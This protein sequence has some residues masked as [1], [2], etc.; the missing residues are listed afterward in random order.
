MY[1]YQ[2]E[3][4]SAPCELHIDALSA[5]IADTAAKVVFENAKR[6]EQ[7]YSFFRNDSELHTLN[8]RS[9]NICLLSDELSGLIQLSLF[10]RD[11]T[12]GAFDIAMA[13]TLKESSNA[14]STLEYHAKRK[15]LLPFASS[16]HLSLEGNCLTFTNPITK[17]DLGGLVKEYAVDQSI[18][19]LQSMEITS[20][21][22]NFGGDIAAFGTCH[23]HSWRVGIQNPQN[24]ETNLAEIE[25]NT[26]SLCTSGHSKRYS[27][28]QFEKISHIIGPIDAPSSYSQVSILAPTTVDAGIWSTAMLV[29]PDLTLPNHIKMV[30]SIP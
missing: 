15:T 23:D 19:Q 16:S 30:H 26:A 21:L 28:I 24:P 14:S 27:I 18:L 20:G 2:F 6:L 8:T 1:Y 7:R 17:I 10:Y 9:S 29:N 13:G 3:A 4:F 12:L 22:V 11:K 25:L 5:S